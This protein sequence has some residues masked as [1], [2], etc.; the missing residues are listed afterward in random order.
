MIG[1]EYAAVPFYLRPNKSID[2][3]LLVDLLVRAIPS[4]RIPYYA[5]VGMPGVDLT[6]IRSIHRHVG[7]EHFYCI[8]SKPDVHTRQVFNRPFPKVKCVHEDTGRFIDNIEHVQEVFPKAEH[9]IVWLDYDSPKLLAQLQEFSQLVKSLLPGDIAKITLN[10]EMSRHIEAGE[11]NELDKDELRKRVRE[12]YMAEFGNEFP[13]SAKNDDMTSQGFVK[14]VA[15]SLRVAAEKGL[16][17]AAKDQK[18]VVPL[19]ILTYRDMNHRMLTATCEIVE[20]AHAEGFAGLGVGDWQYLAQSWDDIKEIDVPYLTLRERAQ[21][22]GYAYSGDIGEKADDLPFRLGNKTA[23]YLR[24]YEFY[25]RFYP[26]FL[27]VNL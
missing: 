12:R 24:Q 16:R 11:Q 23:E 4:T 10:A 17:G 26:S 25:L 13:V 22:E 7:I 9:L 8:E 27:D 14:I 3:A 20:S 15:K 18:K 2:R 6:E 1:E 5:Y 21:V 19:S